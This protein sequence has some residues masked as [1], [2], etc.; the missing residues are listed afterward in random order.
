MTQRA[1]LL[2]NL[3]SPCSPTEADVRRYLDQFLMDPYV[4][5]LPWLLRRFIVSALVLPKR[6]RAS[7]AAYDSIWMEQ[8]S[9][10]LVLSRRL[11]EALRRRLN[12]PVALAMRY[13]QP[14]IE[15]QLLALASQPGICEVLYSP[16][17]PHAA[18]STVT[19]SVAEA[20]RVI[21]EHRLTLDLN[22][23]PPFYEHPEYIS[24]L[25]AGA[26]PAI[27][28][29][30]GEYGS[31]DSGKTHIL[32]S[33]HGLPESHVLKADPSGRHCLRQTTCCETPSPAHA[34]CYR[35]QILRTTRCF[36]EQAGLDQGHY[37]LAYQSRLGRAKWL[38]PSTE[39]VL[40]ELAGKG[41]KKLLV[42]CPAFVTDCL[43]TLEEIQIRGRKVF[44]EAGGE[45]LELIPCLNDQPQWVQVLTNWCQSTPPTAR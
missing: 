15:S 10:L 9:P 18:D 20:Q 3:G 41:V 26:R 24:A 2:A 19:T 43:E 44:I 35:H 29:A 36:V 33:Y 27:E 25:V 45:A 31:L 17:Y 38:E 13:G 32:F 30:V 5:Q 42:V 37:S 6:P 14:D 28:R 4:I 1:V 34:T 22:V 23:L 21:R 40:R 8:G 39:A 12:M 7:A 11:C 16:L